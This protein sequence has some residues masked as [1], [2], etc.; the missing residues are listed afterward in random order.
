MFS[1][2]AKIC[3]GRGCVPGWDGKSLQD[4][5]GGWDGEA[6]EAVRFGSRVVMFNP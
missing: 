2:E 4:L 3:V 6:G 1:N 5:G